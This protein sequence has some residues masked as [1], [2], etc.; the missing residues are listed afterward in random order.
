[1]NFNLS[2]PQKQLVMREV[3][4]E[5]LIR[6]LEKSD[7]R[8]IHNV[9]TLMNSLYSKASDEDKSIIVEVRIVDIFY[10]LNVS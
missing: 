6:H 5:S 3:P 10:S 1:M 9:L 2:E 4:F 8:V 7:E